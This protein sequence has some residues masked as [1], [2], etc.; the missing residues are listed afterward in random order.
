MLLVT[1]PLGWL[2]DRVGPVRLS[3]LAFTLL[4]V[5][6]VLLLAA[7]GTSTLAVA[8]FVYG[9]GMAGV[10]FG[11]MLGPVALAGSPEKVPQYVA[12]HA[13]LVGVRGI[14]FQFLGMAFYKL[15]GS[16]IW[17]L[18]VAALTFAWAAWQL[19][20]LQDALRIAAAPVSAPAAPAAAER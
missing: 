6:P 7:T 18:V 5:Y 9:L 19:W 17:P 1:P 16:F 15:T 13:T 4:A 8:S 12:I 20:Q 10:Q 3:C 14:H 11:W 2:Q